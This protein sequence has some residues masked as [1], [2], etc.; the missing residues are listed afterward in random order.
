MKLGHRRVS[1]LRHKNSELLILSQKLQREIANYRGVPYEGFVGS[2][3][4]DAFTGVSKGP[5]TA[6]T[7]V[8]GVQKHGV[9]GG[10][11]KRK[12]RRHP[13]PDENAPERPP[14]AYV[15]FSNKIREE[16][17]GESLSF[18]EIAKLVGD[19]WQKLDPAEKE[20]YEAQA[21]AAKDRYTL[22][23]SAYKKTDA[24]KDYMNYLADFRAKHGPGPN[25]AK[26]PKLEPELSSGSLSGKS[27]ELSDPH[28]T[29]PSHIRLGSVGSM[30][31]TSL[32]TTL[33]SPG[34]ISPGVSSTYSTLPPL[35]AGARIV[36]ASPSAASP[37]GSQSR[38]AKVLGP[39]STRSSVSDDSVTAVGDN[40][41]PLPRASRLT[42]QTPPPGHPLMFPLSSETSTTSIEARKGEERPGTN[43]LPVEGSS[44]SPFASRMSTTT[45]PSLKQIAPPDALRQGIPSEAGWTRYSDSRKDRR[46]SSTFGS[47]SPF[48]SI[49]SGGFAPKERVMDIRQERRILPPPRP[50]PPVGPDRRFLE[51]LPRG[52]NHAS[53]DKFT[54]SGESHSPTSAGGAPLDKSESDAVNTLAGLASWEGERHP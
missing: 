25:E 15:I 17:K 23:L 31:S 34:G 24:Y 30:G 52:S 44:A 26:K 49:G 33:P 51:M 53:R 11:T 46:T 38:E 32:N 37:G 9:S 45:M 41:D 42:L 7:P 8:T 6:Q 19:K 40:P 14:S 48:G 28:G 12:Y 35:A 4:H 2:A 16:T 1:S 27:A 22:Q 20:R 29:V 10:E 13:K 21:A 3:S 36:T 54:A 50:S 5:G 47:S 18:T 43:A 39:L